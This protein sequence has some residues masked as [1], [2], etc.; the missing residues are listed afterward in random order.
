M[1][2]LEVEEYRILKDLEDRIIDIFQILDSTMDT[3]TSITEN[4]IKFLYDMGYVSENRIE[5]VFDSIVLALQEKQREV[6]FSRRKVESLHRKIKETTKL[7]RRHVFLSLFYPSL[8]Y[9]RNA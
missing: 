7:V 3:I 6:R 8:L 5:L 4:Y 9:V 1:R 2:L